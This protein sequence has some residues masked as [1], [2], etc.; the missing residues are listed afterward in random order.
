M[1]L[2]ETMIDCGIKPEVIIMIKNPARISCGKVLPEF[3][4]EIE[5]LY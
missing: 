1:P 5:F 2:R 3:L 4:S